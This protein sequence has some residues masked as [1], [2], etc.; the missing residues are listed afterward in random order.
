[1]LLGRND[2]DTSFESKLPADTVSS[3]LLSKGVQ[4]LFNTN[5]APQTDLYGNLPF[6]FPTEIDPSLAG[7]FD[8]STTPFSETFP[9][10]IYHAKNNKASWIFPTS[11]DAFCGMDLDFDR[12]LNETGVE[13]LQ[14]SA[15]IMEGHAN[16]FAPSSSLQTMMSALDLSDPLDSVTKLWLRLP[17]I[18]Q[19]YDLELVEL[20]L[21]VGQRHLSTTF[22]TF[23]GQLID[24]HTLPVQIIAMAAVGALFSGCSE[25]HDI[26]RWLFTD[27]LRM[28]SDTLFRLKLMSLAATGS[29]LK[30]LIALELCGLCSGH[31]RSNEISEA[32]HQA[33]VQIL[34]DFREK[35]R[36]T[37]EEEYQNFHHDVLL[38][39][40]YRVTLLQLQPLCPPGQAITGKDS[41][42][43][44]TPSGPDSSPNDS[45][46]DCPLSPPPLPSPYQELARISILSYFTF[47]YPEHRKLM[48]FEQN[49]RP[50]TIEVY[51]YD[52]A[53][54]YRSKLRDMPSLEIL[55]RTN[56][57]IMRSPVEI[58]HR[59]AY[60][61]AQTGHVSSNSW[62][63][64]LSRWRN[65][66]N[67]HIMVDHVVRV[68]DRAEEL[69]QSSPRFVEA[70]HDAFSTYLGTL[71][72]CLSQIPAAS[73]LD[74]QSEITKQIRRGLRIVAKFRVTSADGMRRIL[75]LVYEKVIL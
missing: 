75:S 71:A 27:S 43:F 10:K 16:D 18:P 48:V 54:K 53:T 12:L 30:A 65:H 55:L 73:R 47:A 46:S 70:P 49:W 15:T 2:Y 72:L 13:F 63:S 67:Y 41:E 57:W 17:F 58:F 60:E 3:G 37:N 50:E 22:L 8:V 38:L 7:N 19:R 74:E 35:S 14:S 21:T 36:F 9:G 64:F 51:M 25:S 32:Y 40:A 59:I 69:V 31:M 11:T 42:L 34:T 4:P 26:G 5:Q 52:F 39:E 62:V 45:N 6:Y 56:L 66:P 44:F 23:T 29:F 20:L 28:V 33:L 24:K 61:I 1:M 68:L